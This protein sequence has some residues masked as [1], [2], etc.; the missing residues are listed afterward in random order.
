M[1]MTN[2]MVTSIAMLVPLNPSITAIFTVIN[3][4]HLFAFVLM[5]S[6]LILGNYGEETMQ[7]C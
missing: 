4:L 3:L 7:Q 5:S 6:V 1:F 2:H